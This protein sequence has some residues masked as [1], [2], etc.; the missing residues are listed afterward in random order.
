MPF[1]N[2]KP[3]TSQTIGDVI[4]STLA[5]LIAIYTELAAHEANITNAHGIDA[6]IA[7]TA[8]YTA[9]KANSSTAHGI[10]I[11]SALASAV[12]AEIVAARGSQPALATRLAVALQANG[13]IKLSSIA[14][15]WLDNGDVPTFVDSTHFTV[16][17]DRTKVYI[18]GVILRCTVSAEYAYAAIASCSFGAGVT[19]VVLDPLY[20][21]LTSGL[22]KVEIGLIAWD[23]S[24]AAAATQ[25][26]ADIVAL[27]GQITALS[28]ESAHGYKTG[29]PTASE[30]LLRFMVTRAFSVPIDCVGSKFKATT[31]ATAET[32]F[33]LVKNGSNFGTATF[34]A[35]ATSAVFAAASATSFAVGDVLL[36]R[37]PATPDATLNHP[38]FNI[39][40][41]LT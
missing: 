12:N 4:V 33:D 27:Q 26:A 32:V 37:A 19:T 25:N 1:D 34:A 35:G 41:S 28:V 24:V 40:G 36:V 9:H 38:V 15:K 13:G 31:A 6:L 17:G 5:N 11:V 16:P 23:N 8:D 10:D 7:S 20:P 29:L 18:A 3:N 30:V 39:K 2:T 21:V 14:S 22:S